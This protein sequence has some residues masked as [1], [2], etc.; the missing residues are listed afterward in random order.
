MAQRQPGAGGR[1]PFVSFYQLIPTAPDPQRADPAL[2]GSMPARAQQYC[3]PLRAASGYGWHLFAPFTFELQWDG[4]R[5]LWRSGATAPWQAVEGVDAPGLVGLWTLQAPISD[6]LPRPFHVLRTAGYEPGVVTIWTGLLARTQPDWS[7][8]VRAPVNLPRDPAYDIL[9][10]VVETD[11]WFGPLFVVVQFRKTDVPVRF[12]PERPLAQAQPVPQQA[13]AEERLRDSVCVRGLP[14][15]LPAD[16]QA[17]AAS[18]LPRNTPGV[19]PGWYR[20]AA[21]RRR[22]DKGG[23]PTAEHG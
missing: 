19:R 22:A 4:V 7:L 8:L 14:A 10:G 11:W 1:T 3:E 21:R 20:A 17:Y 2:F 18:L 5:V 13:Y 15:L 6:V 9:E 16:W 23:R 12:A